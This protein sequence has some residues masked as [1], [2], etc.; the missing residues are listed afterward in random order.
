MSSW[1]ILIT[2]MQ[3]GEINHNQLLL[4]TGVSHEINVYDK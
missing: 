1:N 4:T 3:D 2:Y